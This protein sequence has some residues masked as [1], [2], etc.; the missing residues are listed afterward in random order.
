MKNLFF[1]VIALVSGALSGHA[2]RVCSAKVPQEVSQA[3]GAAYPN[4][5]K[6]RWERE[7]N[8]Y[9]AEFVVGG[10]HLEAVYSPAGQLMATEQPVA[11][12]DLPKPV[13]E[14]LTKKFGE[15]R[16]RKV[17]KVQA[18]GQEYYS[19]AVRHK[20]GTEELTYTATGQTVAKP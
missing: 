14:Q 2:Q 7:D 12:T 20:R 18:Q 5:Q 6:V 3:F 11:S 16:V 13:I 10:K 1:L 17:E 15:Y 8:A 9:E 19:V 4:A